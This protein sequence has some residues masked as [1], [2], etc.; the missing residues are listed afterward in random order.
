M[1]RGIFSF[2]GSSRLGNRSSTGAVSIEARDFV[3]A[4][5]QRDP[6]ARLSASQ[7]MRHP[8]LKGVGSGAVTPPSRW[9]RRAAPHKEQFEG[10]ARRIKEFS[11]LPQVKRTILAALAKQLT[12][13]QVRRR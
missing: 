12:E 10:V 4:L 8:W 11:A 7:A 13:E 5:L 2:S 1:L 9:R 3:S 6:A